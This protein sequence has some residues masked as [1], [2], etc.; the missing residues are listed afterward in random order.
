MAIVKVKSH[1]MVCASPG[2]LN[3]REG[4]GRVSEDFVESGTAGES[5]RR[6]FWDDDE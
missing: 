5:R 6:S 3:P 2:S 4:T 1:S